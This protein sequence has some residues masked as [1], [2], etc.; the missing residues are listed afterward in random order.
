MSAVGI[1]LGTTYSC[2][3]VWRN[4]S[5]DIIAN[6]MGERTTP[7]Y[8]SFS[9]TERLIGQAAK[10]Q[11]AR[12]PD[13][14]V[15]DAKRLIGRKFN[16]PIVQADCKLWP[17]KVVKGS[18]ERPVIEVTFKGEKR[19]FFPEEISSMVLSKM[20]ET[21]EASLGTKVTDAVVTVPAYF[22]DSQRQATKD[23]GRIAELNVLRI[24]NE[25]T[26]AAIAYGL[27]KSAEEE[28]NVLIFDLGGGTFDVSLLTIDDGVFEVMATA[29]N[30]HLGGED[31]DN[32][33]VDYCVNEFKKKTKYDIR[34]SA[35]AMRRLRTQCEQAKRTLSAAVRA[36]IEVDSLYEGEDF[37]Q[38]LTRAR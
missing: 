16:D 8:V 3:G 24:I 36:T 31:F 25:P 6:D 37:N 29:G 13:N 12:N 15:F 7:S 20:K 9:D 32:K 2:V 26:A 34:N 5:V 33:L 17:F 35:R 22:N 4:D 30:T 1:D 38:T 14:T 19:Q 11:S 21:A 10:N 28:R 27:D 18:Q 23:A